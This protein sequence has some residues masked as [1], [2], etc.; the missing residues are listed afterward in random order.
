M[1]NENT[2]HD[3]CHR[4]AVGGPVERVV[5]RL[6]NE[7]W[8]DEHMKAFRLGQTVRV[9]AEIQ[10]A[11]PPPSSPAQESLA[12]KTGTVV[13]LRRADEAAWV[14]MDCDLPSALRS[15]QADDEHGRGN[16]IILWPQECTAVR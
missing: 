7:A 16:H 14:R 10:C 3:E 12:G 2:P 1:S 8:I 9:L 15:F 4:P 6:V 5:G 11:A 13:R